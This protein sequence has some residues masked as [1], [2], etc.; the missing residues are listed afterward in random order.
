MLPYNFFQV[1]KDKRRKLLE[2]LFRVVDF[3]FKEDSARGHDLK[4]AIDTY[5]LNRAKKEMYYESVK[6]AQM[7]EINSIPLPEAPFEFETPHLS[8]IP[9]P[10]I[11]PASILKKLPPGPPIGLPPVMQGEKKPPGP[12]P[13]VPPAKKVY[14]AFS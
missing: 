4:S 7:V 2:T 12:P 9:L 10:G 5:K 8:E 6:N 14:V 13:G 3:Y 11:K 1:I